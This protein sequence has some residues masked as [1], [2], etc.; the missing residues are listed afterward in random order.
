MNDLKFVKFS[1]TEKQKKT[2]K[3]VEV[4][5]LFFSSFKTFQL[6]KKI[7]QILI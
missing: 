3:G 2:V 7:Y 5:W 1:L 6:K 4:K